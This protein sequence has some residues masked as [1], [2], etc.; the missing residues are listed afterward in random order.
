MRNWKTC[1]IAVVAVTAITFVGPS[2]AR[3]DHHGHF[4]G[5]GHVG[6]HHGHFGGHHVGHHGGFGHHGGVQALRP[7]L[8][9]YSSGYYGYGGGYYGG[10]GTYGVPLQRSY[11]VV[12]PQVRHHRWH[13][14]HYLFHH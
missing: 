2:T 13:P 14:G 8:P 5:H 3:A 10:V 4:G 11:R 6:G 1:A 9:S 12:Q 7:A